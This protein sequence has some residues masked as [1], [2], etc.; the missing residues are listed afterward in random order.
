MYKKEKNLYKNVESNP[1]KYKFSFLNP[2]ERK[3]AY[4][5]ILLFIFGLII[6]IFEM[7]GI[8]NWHKVSVFSGAVDGIKVADTDFAVYYLDVGQ[9]DC[10][11]VVCDGE[12][13]LIDTGSYPQLVDIQEALY[14]LEV[15][16]I[17]YLV[18]THQH[19]DH[20][21]CAERLMGLYNI[22]N[23]VMPRL[24][25]ENI[26]ESE[27]YNR[28]LHT[29]VTNKVNPIVS[30][31]VDCLDLGSAKIDILAPQKQ[32]KELN[33][34]STVI[35]I[36]YGE[37]SFLFQGDAESQVEN[38]LLFSDYDL[39]ADVLKLGHHGSK[40]ASTEKYLD[41]VNPNIAIISCGQG[42]PFGH[43]RV[44]VMEHLVKRD[45][46]YY[47]TVDNGDITVASDGKK[48]K[49]SHK[50]NQS[51]NFYSGFSGNTHKN[52]VKI[53]KKYLQS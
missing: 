2:K 1:N 27:T 47:I 29:I 38:D 5:I 15:D 46:D 44:T 33:N 26:V 4:I 51:M 34:M 12:V 48:L 28:L 53:V 43:P 3:K 7:F 9:S 42:N 16:D 24:S 41:A 40:T 13:M 8:T 11:I 23:I 25:D 39:S 14:T 36:T 21:S 30:Q 22:E 37:T 52:K 50:S 10:T 17:K 45:I 6:T 35:K 20:M 19:D 31:E 32:Y 49:C 18:I